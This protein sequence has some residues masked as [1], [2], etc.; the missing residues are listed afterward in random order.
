MG[1][2]QADVDFGCAAE[3]GSSFV[4]REAQRGLHAPGAESFELQRVRRDTRVRS[5]RG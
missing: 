4:N 3:R 1:R 2:A 5:K